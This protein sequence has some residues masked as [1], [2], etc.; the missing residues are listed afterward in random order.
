LREIL[1]DWDVEQGVE[2]RGRKRKAVDEGID[3]NPPSK[4][5]SGTS[6]FFM[7]KEE[8][9]KQSAGTPAEPETFIDEYCHRL[10]DREAE[11]DRII[12]KFVSAI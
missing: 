9:I 12:A 10:R 7:T 11:K 4:R 5:R 8:L 3:E 2:K 6:N 1:F